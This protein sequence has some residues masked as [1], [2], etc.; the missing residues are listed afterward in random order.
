MALKTV[1]KAKGFH[2]VAVETTEEEFIGGNIIAAIQIL[3]KQMKMIDVK[4][5]DWLP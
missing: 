2:I 5:M 1:W 3:Q 4:S